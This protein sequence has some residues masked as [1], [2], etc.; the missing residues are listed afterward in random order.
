MFRK[1]RV[2]VLA[3]TD[4]FREK[5][6]PEKIREFM[7]AVLEQAPFT[8]DLE[9]YQKELME[10][11][12]DHID[13]ASRKYFDEY[14]SEIGQVNDRIKLG[15]IKKEDIEAKVD[16]AKITKAYNDLHA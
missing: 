4:V 14:H 7:L 13:E 2:N 8:N 6:H 16:L 12:D 3:L 9:T 5:N 15:L 10:A 1:R 11:D